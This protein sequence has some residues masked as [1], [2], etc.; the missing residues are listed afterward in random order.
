MEGRM[1]PFGGSSGQSGPSSTGTTSMGSL[2]DM[3]FEDM[4]SWLESDLRMEP[5]VPEF[6]QQVNGLLPGDNSGGG[7]GR[8]G[9]LL[10]SIPS[11]DMSDILLGGALSPSGPRGMSPFGMLSGSGGTAGS[12]NAFTKPS[13]LGPSLPAGCTSSS[14]A[15]HH[16][17][18]LAAATSTTPVQHQPAPLLPSPPPPPLQQAH[19]V[20]PKINPP[21]MV[22]LPPGMQPFTVS[23]LPKPQRTYGATLTNHSHPPP[24]GTQMQPPPMRFPAGPMPQAAAQFT[25]SPTWPKPSAPSVPNTANP[26]I[27]LFASVQGINTIQTGLPL[28]ESG[29]REPVHGPSATP[30]PLTG[31]GDSILPPPVSSGEQ[32][33]PTK[34]AAELKPPE[35]QGKEEEVNNALK[36]EEQDVLTK[37]L[38]EFSVAQLRPNTSL[39]SQML[40]VKA[41][42]SKGGTKTKGRRSA[43][44]K[45]GD[46][47]RHVS[48]L[49]A[50]KKSLTEE[51]ENLQCRLNILDRMMQLRRENTEELAHQHVRLEEQLQAHTLARE[52]EILHLGNSTAQTKSITQIFNQ[53]SSSALFDEIQNGSREYIEQMATLLQQLDALPP[54]TDITTAPQYE[55]LEAHM[56]TM[57]NYVLSFAPRV[58]GSFT[59]QW[60]LRVYASVVESRKDALA[61]VDKAY[62][63]VYP[64][65]RLTHQQQQR[66]KLTYDVYKRRLTENTAERKEV[67]EAITRSL[68]VSSDA[69]MVDRLREAL[70]CEAAL[71][72][73]RCFDHLMESGHIMAAMIVF[74]KIL[75]RVQLARLII[76]SYPLLPCMWKLFEVVDYNMNTSPVDTFVGSA[77][78]EILK[79]INPCSHGSG[80]QGHPSVV[81]SASSNNSMEGPE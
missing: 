2:N 57:T 24:P 23:T 50:L 12:S 39:Y 17:F 10:M 64:L 61:E 35:S 66:L 18:S 9:L 5:L 13:H 73:L 48:E 33:Y 6:L 54:G 81:G 76:A 30:H 4:I 68:P 78:E 15:Q 44:E 47:E 7:G 25:Q 32:C 70:E 19:P 34:P 46:M 58:G 42:L 40:K 69:S 59:Q 22:G 20:P 16:Q 56:N 43:K 60:Q 71:M 72:R 63:D 31:A 36:S 14:P 11:I 79:E 21:H 65:L 29:S 77:V 74:R 28:G 1:T 45:L 75:N 8:T 38:R 80:S 41:A 27:S 55:A 62:R 26:A 51:T 3:G 52:T 67:V 53:G 49:Q 37:I